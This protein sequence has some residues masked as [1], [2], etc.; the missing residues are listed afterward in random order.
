MASCVRAS[1]VP[2]WLER[3]VNAFP[4]EL[5]SADMRKLREPSKS[6]ARTL[7]AALRPFGLG[8]FMV[9]AKSV[10]FAFG[11]SLSGMNDCQ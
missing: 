9:T 7:Y 4:C 10:L 11:T 5:S 3:D 6:A 2:S 8:S 1:M